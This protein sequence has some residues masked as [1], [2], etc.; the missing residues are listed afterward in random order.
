MTPWWEWRIVQWYWYRQ[1]K[2]ADR[3][4]FRQ[5]CQDIRDRAKTAGDE[6]P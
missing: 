1:Y 3:R 2:R 5:E 6:T 4:A